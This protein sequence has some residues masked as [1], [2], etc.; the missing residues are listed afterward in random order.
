M[1]KNSRNKHTYN[2]VGTKPYNLKGGNYYVKNFERN[3]KE[4]R[5]TL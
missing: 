2:E 1:T 5:R 4:L 3:G